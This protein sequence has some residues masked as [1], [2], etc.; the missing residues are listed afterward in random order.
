MTCFEELPSG[1]GWLLRDD[2]RRLLSE[3]DAWIEEASAP[4]GG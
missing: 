1:G 3:F 2:V 4:S